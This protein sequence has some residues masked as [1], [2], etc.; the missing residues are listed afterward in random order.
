MK[1]MIVGVSSPI[2]V[3]HQ[4]EEGNGYPAGTIHIASC[5]SVSDGYITAES[6]ELVVYPNG[7]MEAVG[8]AGHE[9]IMFSEGEDLK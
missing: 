6:F 8:A 7:N 9:G 2:V 4:K 5:G 1:A 3:V